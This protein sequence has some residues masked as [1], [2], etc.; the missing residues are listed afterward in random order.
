MS[1]VSG[2]NYKAL[3]VNGSQ[4]LGSNKSADGS[5]T[6]YSD[7]LSID[8]LK[9]IDKNSD[10]IITEKEFKKVCKSKNSDK[11]WKTYTNFYKSTASKSKDGSS[12]V[13]Q[14][15][16]NGNKVQ[17]SFDKNGNLTGYKTVSTNRDKSTTTIVYNK[18]GERATKTIK[19]SD[20][21]STKYN[22]STKS[23]NHTGADGSA[24]SM[25]SKGKITNVKAGNTNVS[26]SYQANKTDIKSI[27]IGNKQYNNITKNK[28]GKIVVKDENG[29]AVLSIK[30]KKNGETSV[31]RYA[32]GK[33]K[34]AVNLNSDREP[35]SVSTYDKNGYA[36]KRVYS[37]SGRTRT[38]ERDSDG[39]VLS[40]TD[41]NKDGV[42][43]SK[44]TYAAADGSKYFKNN[45]D[46]LWADRVYYNKDG[47]VKKYETYSYS[48]NSDSTVTKTTDTYADETKTAE[49]SK[50]QTILNSYRNKLLKKTENL[51]T[52]ET[53][54]KQYNYKDYYINK[55]IN[56]KTAYVSK[57]HLA[58]TV[59]KTGDE[60]VTKEYLNGT[61]VDTKTETPENKAD[62]V[63][64]VSDSAKT[65][66]D[67]TADE[68]SGNVPAEAPPA[69]TSD[70]SSGVNGSDSGEDKS[71]PPELRYNENFDENGNLVSGNY[72][73]RA[74]LK[75]L[76]PDMYTKHN[77][78]IAR[79]LAKKNN[80]EM[81]DKVFYDWMLK[82][83][84]IELP[85]I[86]DKGYGIYVAVGLTDSDLY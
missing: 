84:E 34:E 74:L 41:Y 9:K 52:G 5:G 29:N 20:G 16:A 69:D 40:S 75:K 79:K 21:S 4:Q 65:P 78:D 60:T 85:E 47:S 25:N 42:K 14:T 26:V 48:K 39:N 62:S 45:S 19:C 58:S 56:Y 71:L 72:T 35:K 64:S 57:K 1:E 27:K 81:T 61:V 70:K 37:N 32:D 76:Y 73:L 28:N 17:S 53:S 36:V 12:T 68:S 30:T 2:L 13:T 31:V 11:Y 50:S 54:E 77:I 18:A 55:S 33:K 7:G 44:Q 8:E 67:G 82:N 51:Q 24:V 63:S 22:Y 43:T 6:D 80:L 86:Y 49:K 10:G 46:A 3:G 38:Y 83:C 59:T 23:F 66:P 15:L